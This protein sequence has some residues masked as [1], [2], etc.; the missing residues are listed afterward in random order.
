MPKITKHDKTKIMF[1]LL[2]SV[3]MFAIGAML[4]AQVTMVNGRPAFVSS[5]MDYHSSNGDVQQISIYTKDT[6]EELRDQIRVAYFS[7]HDG[8]H[9]YFRVYLPA[10]VDSKILVDHL[11]D[12]NSCTATGAHDPDDTLAGGPPVRVGMSEFSNIHDQIELTPE[13]AKSPISVRCTVGSVAAGHTFTE[14]NATFSFNGKDA[15]E[16]LW[17]TPDLKGY[18]PLSKEVM[19]FE[20]IDGADEFKFF[21]GYEDRKEVSA[22]SVRVLEPDQMVTVT[23]T[24]VTREQLRDLILVLIGTVIGIAVTMLIEALRLILDAKH[25]FGP[26]AK[27][28]AGE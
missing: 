14:R 21:G 5:K 25:L 28:S 18:L 1:W 23:W 15:S 2:L 4:T 9:P 8:S 13:K 20:W 24:D 19:D 10:E 7:D 3:C 16:F 27:R 26:K 17:I 22:E 12:P 6:S 11:R